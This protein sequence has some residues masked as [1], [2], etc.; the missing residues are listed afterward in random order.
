MKVYQAAFWQE[1][2]TAHVGAVLAIVAGPKLAPA[3][4]PWLL[5]NAKSN[6]NTSEQSPKAGISVK[7]TLTISFSTKR[8]WGCKSLF[9]REK[10][11][12]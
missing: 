2:A 6:R 12:L 3:C 11:G 10:S 4:R 1:N 8:I 7:F 5:T 9:A